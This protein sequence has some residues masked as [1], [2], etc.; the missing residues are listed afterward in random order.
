MSELNLPTGH[1]IE[2]PAS[3]WATRLFHPVISTLT[4]QGILGVDV[5][6][7]YYRFRDGKETITVKFL[8]K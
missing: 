7:D 4:K 8:V 6:E 5:G 3:K 1:E 2:P